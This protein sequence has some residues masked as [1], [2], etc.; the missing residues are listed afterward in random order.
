MFPRV[1]NSLLK[2][3]RYNSSSSDPLFLTNLLKR[4]DQVNT[5]AAASRTKDVKSVKKGKPGVQAKA[6][7]TA[8]T[9]E[10]SPARANPGTARTVKDHPMMQSRFRPDASKASDRLSNASDRPRPSFANRTPQKPRSDRPSN[11]PAAKRVV[12]KAKTAPSGEVVYPTKK[13][14]AGPFEPKVSGDTFLYGKLTSVNPCV[15]SRVASIT[16]EALIDSKYPYLLPKSIIDTLGN[17]KG[18]FLAKANY[19][20]DVDVQKVGARFNEVVLG[21]TVDI[22]VDPKLASDPHAQ[23]THGQI[24]K[25]ATVS[26]EKKQ[27]MFDAVNGLKSAKEVVGNAPWVKA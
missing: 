26:L 12:R 11:R 14:T 10:F 27:L 18:K 22:K 4:L 13:V 19:S 7:K 5:T 2:G 25:N 17:P 20:L 6:P 24:M 9:G 1:G 23:F 8:A 15:S 3:V 16:K 21:R